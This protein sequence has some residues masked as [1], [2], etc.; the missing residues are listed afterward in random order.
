[1]IDKV[2]KTPRKKAQSPAELWHCK[3][4]IYMDDMKGTGII[5]RRVLLRPDFPNYLDDH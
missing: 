2:D 5:I 3:Y 4:T 1:M